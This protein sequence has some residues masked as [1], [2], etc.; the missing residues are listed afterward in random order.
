MEFITANLI[1]SSLSLFAFF[2][3]L[4]I[5]ADKFVDYSSILAKQIGISE[6]TIGLTIIALGT[7][8]P[9]IF[10]G[11]ASVYGEIENLA[12]GAVVGSNIA[13]IGLIFG[14]ACIGRSLRP[15]FSFRNRQFIPLLLAAI[16]L[17]IAF[18]DLQLSLLESITLLLI[19]PIFLYTT[20]SDKSVGVKDK[21]EF[22]N[23]KSE[24]KGLFKI[25]VYIVLAL[26][27]LIVGSEG[28]VSVSTEIAL[29]LEISEVTIGLIV[30][31]IG[32]SLPE[33]AATIS[34]IL[35]KKTDLVIGNVIGSNV[36][37]IVL[38]VPI[39]GF[40]SNVQLKSELIER[41]FPIMMIFTLIFVILVFMQ[42]IKK[43]SNVILIRAFGMLLLSGY[44]VYVF[45]ISA[46][47]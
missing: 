28:V 45:K 19:L 18:Y 20:Y 38:V 1:T 24:K 2:A 27:A 35:K 47:F 43:L 33:L 9:E 26:G 16:I 6:F 42:S 21:T 8:A 44:L 39:V 3:L 36:M 32:T 4:I 30:I 15:E 7:S 41:D 10:V 46:I 29:K 40:F 31:A 25:F 14:V 11:I 22:D 23:S 5:G 13:N 37:N 12:M 17:G 34:A